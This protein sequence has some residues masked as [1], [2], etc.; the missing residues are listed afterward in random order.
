MNFSGLIIFLG[1]IPSV[2]DKANFSG[3]ESK[4]LNWNKFYWLR[5]LSRKISSLYLQGYSWTFFGHVC[6]VGGLLFSRLFAKEA[7]QGDA[8]GRDCDQGRQHS[9]VER[10]KHGS[11]FKFN[12]F[13]FFNN[14]DGR[15]NFMISSEGTN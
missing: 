8:Q 12:F 15:W 5:P 14:F 6:G 11:F 1:S 13:S 2:L 10:R 4:I 7:G 9:D 3:L